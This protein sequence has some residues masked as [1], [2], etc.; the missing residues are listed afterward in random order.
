[1]DIH[2]QREWLI[3]SEFSRDIVRIAME[4]FCGTMSPAEFVEHFW[5][6]R[7]VCIATLSGQRVTAT[8]LAKLL[9]M[10]RNKVVRKLDY[11]VGRGFVLKDGP[12]YAVGEDFYNAGEEALNKSIRLIVEAGNRL[13]ALSK[14]DTNLQLPSYI[15]AA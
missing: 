15:N 2:P 10:R 9:G 8:R 12:Y 6:G 7:A 3:V 5:V 4:G 1:M 14:M 11:L 13:L